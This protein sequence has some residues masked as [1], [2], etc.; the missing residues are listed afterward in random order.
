MEEYAVCSHA[1]ARG[2]Y[3]RR[4]CLPGPSKRQE[5]NRGKRKARSVG[6][7]EAYHISSNQLHHYQDQVFIR[8]QKTTDGVLGSPS[9]II[10]EMNRWSVAQKSK[11]MFACLDQGYHLPELLVALFCIPHH[12]RFFPG[13]A[14]NQ[15]RVCGNWAAAA[16]PRSVWCSLVCQ[17]EEKE[18]TDPKSR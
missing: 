14:V 13:A 4:G 10:V 3:W 12:H 16:R 1:Q 9:C 5:R 2:G 18:V 15:M 17:G 6:S 8:Q 7:Y 11:C